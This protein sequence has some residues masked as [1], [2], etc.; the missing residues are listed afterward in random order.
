MNFFTFVRLGFPSPFAQQPSTLPI[1]E[2]MSSA[3]CK[4]AIW[5]ALSQQSRQTI[6]G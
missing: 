4:G 3:I 5:K 2:K 1:L 6:D